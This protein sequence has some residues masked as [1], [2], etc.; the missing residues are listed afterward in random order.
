MTTNRPLLSQRAYARHRGVSHTAVR[1]AIAAGRITTED[2]RIDPDR[3]DRDWEA[4]TDESKPSSTATKRRGQRRAP[5]QPPESTTS[6]MAPAGESGAGARTYS[7]S[8]GVRESYLARLAKV[9]YEQRISKLV[10]ADQMRVAQ[11]NAA[12]KAR[13]MLIGVPSR[14][15]PLVVG[16]TDVAEIERIMD[17]E[18]NRVCTE[19]AAAVKR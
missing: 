17:I 19:I 11:F 15:A 16:T 12:R 9:D 2:G 8:R 14:I 7:Q 18:I 4:N 13:D 5:W 10:D 3:A 6:T 1:K